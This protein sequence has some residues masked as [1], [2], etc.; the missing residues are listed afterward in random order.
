MI[1]YY[2]DP[3]FPQSLKDTFTSHQ[4][5]PLWLP[6]F[7]PKANFAFID[8]TT[9]QDIATF[10]KDFTGVLVLLIEDEANIHSYLSLQPFYIVRRQHTKEDMQI[11][12]N[13][14]DAYLDEHYATISVKLGSSNLQLATSAIQY[15]ESFNHYLILHTTHGQYT[16]RQNMTKMQA[17]LANFVRVHKSYLVAIS[18][19]ADIKAAELVL[20]DQTVIPIGRAYKKELAS[21]KL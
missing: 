6:K 15:V 18:Q 2:N 5:E 17:Q 8:V 11:L 10:R 16:L 3:L 12:K 21:L 14:L 7:N 1:I 19:I 9:F 13:L 20:K 4:L